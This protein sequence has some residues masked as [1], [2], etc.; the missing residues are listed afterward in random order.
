MRPFFDRPLDT[1]ATYWRVFRVDGVALAFTSHDKALYFDGIVHRA[2]P[3][4]TPSAIRLT[5]GLTDD[6]AEVEGV[7]SHDAI[8]EDDLRNGLFDSASVEIGAV[9]WSNL[10]TKPIYV[11]ALGQIQYDRSGFVAELRSAKTLLDRDLVPRTSPSCRAEFCG[12][13]CNLSAAKFTSFATLVAIDLASNSVEFP[14]R[15]SADYVDGKVRFL[16]GPQTG[17]IFGIIAV[18]GQRLVLDRPLASAIS[19]GTQ[20]LISQGCDHTLTTCT[21]RFDNSINFRGEAHLP[22]NDLL[23]RY[24]G[25]T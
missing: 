17:I 24:G 22:G 4:M 13:R 23:A 20:A 15:N 10:E 25:N 18:E 7:L 5:A 9:D 11:G 14:T 3:G 8:A 6:D 12:P 2:A 1:I 16:G 19:I 21:Q